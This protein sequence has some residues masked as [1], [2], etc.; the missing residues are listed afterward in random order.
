MFSSFTFHFLIIVI[1]I[2]LRKLLDSEISFVWTWSFTLLL[3][4][5]MMVVW[6]SNFRM[7]YIRWY[8][9]FWL[10]LLNLWMRIH[11]QSVHVLRI[12]STLVLSWMNCS[13]SLDLLLAS[14]CSTASNTLCLCSC[15]CPANITLR[16]EIISSSWKSW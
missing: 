13:P 15:I 14:T 9:V 4:S 6:K 10:L 3:T 12:V 5:S 2:I 11:I 7:A 1:M 8:F 16:I